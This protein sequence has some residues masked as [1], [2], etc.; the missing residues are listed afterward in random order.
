MS[1]TDEQLIAQHMVLKDAK[2][3][4]KK[5]Y[6]EYNANVNRMLQAIEGILAMRLLE[7]GGAKPS[8]KT[9]A[10]TAYQRTLTYARVVDKDAFRCFVLD[11]VLKTGEDGGFIDWSEVKKDAVEKH[12][13]ETEGLEP[14]GVKTTSIRQLITRK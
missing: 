8:I 10:G 1:Y 5:S 7:K 4:A 3:A 12:M 2:E 13:T 11:T 14:P 6:E 9:D